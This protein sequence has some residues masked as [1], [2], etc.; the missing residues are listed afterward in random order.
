MR[1]SSLPIYP[2]RSGRTKVEI[3]VEGTFSC[4]DEGRSSGAKERKKHL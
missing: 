2:D 3:L 1:R 4:T